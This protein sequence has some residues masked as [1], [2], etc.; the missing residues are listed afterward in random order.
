[1]PQTSPAI[2]APSSCNESAGMDPRQG[3]A[4]PLAATFSL[5]DGGTSGTPPRQDASP[6]APSAAV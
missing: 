4:S 1:M 5:T 2:P 3:S 6:T